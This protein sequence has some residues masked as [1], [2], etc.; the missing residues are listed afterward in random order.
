M[1]DK[2]FRRKEDLPYEEPNIDGNVWPHQS[3]PKFEPREGAVLKECWYCCHADFHLNH[4]RALE[5]GVCC[6]PKIILK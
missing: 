1:A 3:C 2:I 6:W 4:V 5:V